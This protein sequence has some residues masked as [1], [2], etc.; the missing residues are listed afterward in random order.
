MMPACH[1]SEWRD[2]FES[3]PFRKTQHKCVGFSFL[4]KKWGITEQD[5]KLWTKQII[6]RV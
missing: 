3:R 5:Q 4:I 6:L 2:G 1:P